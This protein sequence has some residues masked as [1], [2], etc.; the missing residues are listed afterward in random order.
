M[1]TGIFAIFQGL[2]PVSIGFTLMLSFVLYSALTNEHLTLL[3]KIVLAAFA[4]LLTLMIAVF[5]TY[6]SKQKAW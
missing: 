5:E 3:H 1:K 4:L 6:E 2:H